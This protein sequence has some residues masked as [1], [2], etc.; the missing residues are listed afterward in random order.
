M[1]NHVAVKIEFDREDRTYHAGETVA[2]V[3]TLTAIQDIP[4]EAITSHLT[5]QARQDGSPLRP[6]RYP[7]QGEIE[8]SPFGTG[9]FRAG[10]TIRQERRYSLASDAAQGDGER[11]SGRWGVEIVAKEAF[12][13]SPSHFEPIVVEG[14]AGSLSVESDGAFRERSSEAVATGALAAGGLSAVFLVLMVIAGGELSAAAQLTAGNLLCVLVTGA[15]L[16]VGGALLRGSRH[17]ARMRAEIGEIVLE[18]EAPPRIGADVPFR[19]RFADGPPREVVSAQLR[20]RCVEKTRIK[21]RTHGDQSV[22]FWQH[23]THDATSPV[24]TASLSGTLAIPAGKAPSFQEKD[25][26]G[27]EA[28]I[29]WTARVILRLRDPDWTIDE[30]I[31]IRVLAPRPSA[32]SPEASAPT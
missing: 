5:F 31:P 7:A 4:F 13:H 19:I 11:L 26:F 20:V 8:G 12:F 15:C 22:R 6:F 3:V 16:V 23:P 27:D 21:S 24:P 28:G 32:D 29:V 2:A 17:E 30:E 25:G 9:T 18:F 14:I 10:E 1:I